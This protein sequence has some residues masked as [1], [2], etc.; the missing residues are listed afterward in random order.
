VTGY[1]PGG[2]MP[3]GPPEGPPREID[4]SGTPRA[5][6]VLAPNPSPMTLDGTNTWVIAEPGSGT[7]VVV[8]PGPADEDHLRR[9]ADHVSA[10]GRRVELILLT[11]GH[12]DHSG[13]AR[14]FAELTSAAVRALDPAHRLGEEGLNGGDVIAAGGCE[15][16][17]V[18]SP[19]HSADSLC[20]LLSA[21]Q[22]LLTGD[23]VL[24]RGT[25]VIARD[26]N[27]GDYLRSL[28]AL[29]S[30][31]GS[32]HV[33]VL[34][35]GHGPLARD[36]AATLDHYIAHR[37]ERL[38]EVEAALDAGDRTVDEIVGRVYAQ[39]DPA[40]RPFAAWSVRAQLAYLAGRGA[41]PP[42][43]TF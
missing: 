38:A 11:H 22:A 24:G 32:A 40:V 21:D 37:A 41:L 27:L 8:D 5:R 39:I 35:P 1:G 10:G 18:A 9:V 33:R 16:R 6:C 2:A 42:G 3:A 36:P 7:A 13:G 43:V 30:L 25:A 19:G 26:G 28:D 17:V 31:V 23:T 15:L 29:R 12:R 4:G 14:R 20:F 34:M